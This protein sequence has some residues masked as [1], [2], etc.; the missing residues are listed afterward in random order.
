MAR[1]T[2]IIIFKE[3]HDYIIENSKKWHVYKNVYRKR[4]E[5][6]TAKN[7]E[8]AIFLAYA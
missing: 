7:I 6:L 8:A 1:I 4:Y 3:Y 2:N 5:I